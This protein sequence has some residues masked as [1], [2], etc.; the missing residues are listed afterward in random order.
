M[1]S[2]V[3]QPFSVG[4]CCPKGQVDRP[5]AIFE[6][7]LAGFLLVKIIVGNSGILAIFSGKKGK[8]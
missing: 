7:K 2:I 4:K 8:I 3:H 5:A 1:G 6:G